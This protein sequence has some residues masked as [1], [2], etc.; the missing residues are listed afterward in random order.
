MGSR[1][2][3]KAT[4]QTQRA[5]LCLQYVTQTDTIRKV[6]QDWREEQPGVLCSLINAAQDHEMHSD[7]WF[8]SIDKKSSVKAD[9]A[10]YCL[11]LGV[12]K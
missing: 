12:S 11:V 2:W 9:L 1:R 4:I 3:I 7:S 5:E 6:G 10:I 8:H